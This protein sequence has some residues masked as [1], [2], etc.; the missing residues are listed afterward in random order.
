[1]GKTR[2][3]ERSFYLAELVLSGNTLKEWLEPAALNSR[4]AVFLKAGASDDL[5][6]ELIELWHNRHEIDDWE[7]ITEIQV[8]V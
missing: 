4:V 1:M 3:G 2:F 7:E 8:L 5:V 6:K